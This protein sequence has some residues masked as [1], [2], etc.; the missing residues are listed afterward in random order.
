MEARDVPDM[1]DRHDPVAD[2][3]T[4]FLVAVTLLG[5]AIAW[6]QAH[7]HFD[8][9]EATVQAEQWSVLASSQWSRANQEALLTAG[10]RWQVRRDR[11]GAQ[12][13]G[14][15]VLF[16][17][18]DRS[19]AAIEEGQWAKRAEV[20]Q[21]RSELLAEQETEEQERIE[22]D[23]E[24][25]FPGVDSSA[26]LTASCQASPRAP[27]AT[28]I[29]V[30]AGL[31]PASHAPSKSLSAAS[32][33]RTREA[34]RMEGLR[35]ASEETATQAEEQFTTYAI[36]LGLVAVA[37]FLFGYALTRYGFRFRRRFVAVGLL[38]SVGAVAAA[39]I[40]LLEPPHHPPPE[41]AAAYADGQ[42]ALEHRELKAALSHFRCATELDPEFDAALLGRSVAVSQ[43]G[44]RADTQ[45]INLDRQSGPILEESLT[46]ARRAGG[47]DSDDPRVLG[48]MATALYLKGL[49]HHDLGE[50]RRAVA[51][52]E[53]IEE[54]LPQDPIAAYNAGAG[55]LALGR[56]WHETYERAGELLKEAAQG[57]EYVG[58]ALTDLDTLQES[59]LRPGIALAAREAKEAVVA[60]AMEVLS[61]EGGGTATDGRA[62]LG[63][64]QLVVAPAGARVGF[65]AGGF[66]P[67]PGSLFIAIYSHVAHGWQELSQLSGQVTELA[68]P[69]KGHYETGF[70]YASLNSC[71]GSGR[72]KAEVY[73]DGRLANAGVIAEAT[74]QMPMMRARNLPGINVRLCAPTSSNWRPLAQRKVGV[75]DGLERTGARRAGIVVADLSAAPEDGGR[76]LTA[77]ALD[78]LSPPL[79][80]GVKQIGQAVTGLVAEHLIDGRR[81]TY[82]YPGGAMYLVIG[83]T[84]IGRRLAIAAFGPF[85]YLNG[86]ANGMSFSMAESLLA[87]VSPRDE[88]PF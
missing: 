21:S 60:A 10:R 3:I 87:S 48:Q 46:Y 13:A 34:Y 39:A 80:T 16:G 29:A 33:S 54:E 42:V 8:H 44:Q 20:A 51:L 14:A 36:A 57:M 56:D 74:A 17:G 53:Q 59:H 5:A 37:L 84:P 65:A 45:V 62:S 7:A 71:L 6:G 43:R 88:S 41:A 70:H 50:L 68:E 2:W 79:P 82:R 4:F 15:A 76:A 32:Y 66:T 28:R 86:R 12:Q 64:V 58:G 18:R 25:P 78:R 75:V 23:A 55:R 61:P 31:P 49:R 27:P 77:L 22:A 47:E 81:T 63:D 52:D 73:V 69:S 35:D 67:S 19:L 40:A 38:L 30:D 85:G 24:A 11:I 9:D 26:G 83:R 1:L 72:Y